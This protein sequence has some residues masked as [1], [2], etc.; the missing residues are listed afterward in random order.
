MG[1]AM[2]SE[3][4]P[5]NERRGSR[6]LGRGL[7]DISY[8]FLSG[9]AA[10]PSVEPAAEA[11]SNQTTA[12]PAGVTALSVLR[13]GTPLT[14]GQLTAT[15]SECRSALTED[16]LAVGEGIVCSPYGEIDLLAVDHTYRLT[17]IDVQTMLDDGLVAR[18][19]S[20]VDWASRNVATV[21]RLY[22]DWVIDVSR[23]PRLVLVAPRFSLALRSGIRQIS[24]PAISCFRYCEVELSGA[25][26]ILVERI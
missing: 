1:T 12:R 15:L 5:A 19:L 11:A 4:G 16:L 20:H 21:K 3:D 25:A 26:G 6:P 7:E 23:Q 17:I 9:A 14:K 10:V 18:G 22:P 2:P 8:L 13:H 24:A